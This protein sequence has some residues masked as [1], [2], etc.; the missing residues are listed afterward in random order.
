MCTA[1]VG[2]LRYSYLLECKIEESNARP[3]IKLSKEKKGNF[4]GAIMRVEPGKM[5]TPPIL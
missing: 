5:T 4:R 3:K 1:L 2:T